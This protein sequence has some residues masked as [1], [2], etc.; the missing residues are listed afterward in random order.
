MLQLKRVVITLKFLVVDNTQLSER[1]ITM[2]NEI[3]YVFS[4]RRVQRSTDSDFLQGLKVYNESTPYEIKT[5]TNEMTKW[6]D[7]D[8]SLQPF[9]PMFFVLYFSKKVAGLALM[10][11]IKT[12]RLVVLEY[13]SIA[14]KYRVNTVFFSYVNLLENYLKVNRYDVSYIV[15][16]VS[17]RHG[18]TDVDKESR[19]FTK[20]LC[21]EG[22]SKVNATYLTPP[23]GIG[24]HESVFEAFLYMKSGGDVNNIEKQTYVDLIHAIY[25]DYYLPWY[26]IV[27]SDEQYQEYNKSLDECYARIIKE[28][29][30]V[31]LINI[32]HVSCPVLYQ[33]EIETT[34]GTPPARTHAKKA[35]TVFMGILLLFIPVIL[36]WLYNYIL[37]KLGIPLS[38]ASSMAGS[39]ISCIIS[40]FITYSIARKKL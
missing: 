38:T 14:E 7:E 3:E 1:G 20:L 15:N 37:G 6:V 9:E 21:V 39:C 13:V 16:E 36:I 24:N 12:K 17:N 25:Y 29:S 33:N 5:N 18:G 27:L 22:Y 19:L 26:R 4:I 28:I 23:L 10:T 34:H 35:I 2:A 31:S 30:S 32:A 8:A 40:A 11:Y